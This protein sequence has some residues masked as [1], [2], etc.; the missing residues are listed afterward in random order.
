M[1]ETPTIWTSVPGLALGWMVA[2]GCRTDASSPSLVEEAR[3]ACA[4]AVASAESEG[5]KS[6]RSEVRNLLRHGVYKPTGR[7]KPASEYLLNAA[8]GGDFPLINRLVDINN[9]VSVETLLPISL[10][11]LERAGTGRFEARWG[12][13]GESYVFN[14]SGQILGLED[15]LLLAR[16]P[17][18]LPCATP[19][20][21]S[22]ATKT[23]G[24]TR[25]VLGVIYAPISLALEAREA[26]RRMAQLMEIHCGARSEWGG[27]P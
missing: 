18:D 6:R 2:C 17:E 8:L 4:R 14:P 27:A 23:H 25:D 20:K 24:G 22:Q 13:A 10:V 26:A 5:S 1:T 19:V 3:G 12:R 7:G 15:L 11:D 9:L 16:M 21:D